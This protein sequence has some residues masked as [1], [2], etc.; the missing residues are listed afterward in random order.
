M[1][2]VAALET[3]REMYLLENVLTCEKETC[4]AQATNI[5]TLHSKLCVC[6]H[7]VD[8]QAYD[9]TIFAVQACACIPLCAIL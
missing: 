3:I 6:S 8:L 2:I 5:H 1:S 7:F 4:S 9:I